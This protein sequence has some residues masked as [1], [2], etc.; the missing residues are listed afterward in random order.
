M[1]QKRP[2]SVR[3]PLPATHRRGRAA[4]AAALVAAVFA[5]A[6]YAADSAGTAPAASGPAP[7]ALPGEIPEHFTPRTESFDYAQREVM[8][9]MRDGVKLKTVILIPHGAVRAPILLTRTPYGAAGRFSKTASSHLAALLDSSD[10]ADDAVASRRLHPGPA[11][12]PWK[13]RFGGRIP[14]ESAPQGAAQ[15]DLGRS[16]DGHLRHDRLAGE[17][18]AGDPT[19]R[20]AF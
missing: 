2:H 8:I 17:E 11:G 1:P 19:A 16:R 6:A 13:A 20:S 5:M 4:R 14:H 9:P 3:G 7:A 10:V 18:R 12:R 15:S